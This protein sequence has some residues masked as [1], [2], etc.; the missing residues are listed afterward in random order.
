MRS[1]EPTLV[2]FDSVDLSRW[3]VLIFSSTCLKRS[4]SWTDSLRTGAQCSYQPSLIELV[5]LYKINT[6]SSRKISKVREENTEYSYFRLGKR[7]L[8]D[9]FWKQIR[10][11]VKSMIPIELDDVDNPLLLFHRRNQVRSPNQHRS[12]FRHIIGPSIWPTGRPRYDSSMRLTNRSTGIGLVDRWN[13][14]LAEN[15]TKRHRLGRRYHFV[16]IYEGISMSRKWSLIRD[17]WE[18]INVYWK[19]RV[20][21]SAWATQ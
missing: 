7:V 20:T 13:Q 3:K 1:T 17:W 6:H 8:V 18:R 5:E 16:P 11:P 2:P 21:R 15:A 19:Q 10:L 9:F 4:I 14:S 12:M